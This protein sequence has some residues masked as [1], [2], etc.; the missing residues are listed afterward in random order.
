M[1][2]P[3]DKYRDK[4][5]PKSTTEPFSAERNVRA[6]GETWKGRFVIHQHAASRMHFDVRLEVGGTLQSFAVPRG[7]SLDPED[8][9]LAIHTEDHPLEYLFFEDVIPPG[10]YGAGA[11]IVWDAG[12]VTYLETSGEEGLARG[13]IDFV[14][15]G[16]KAKGRFAFIATGRRKAD[17]GLAGTQGAR[18]EWLLIKKRDAHASKGARLAES[19][20][21]SI[22]SGLTVQ[23]LPQ[24]A[25]LA[26][27]AMAQAAALE[28]KY[29][30]KKNPLPK[31]SFAPVPMVC[32]TEGAPEKSPDWVY[33]LKLDGVRIIAEKAGSDVRLSYRSGRVATRNYRDV[34]RSVSKLIADQTILDGEIVTFD[35]S[36][37]PVFGRLAPRIG[38]RKQVD[39]DKAEATV[40]VVYVV[41]DILELGGHNLRAVPLEE[42][43]ALVKK[44][45]PTLGLVRSLD[46]IV[47][48]G[49]ALWALC[50]A[51]DLEGMIAKRR[52]SPYL[53]GP[54]SS[55]HWV[56][57]KRA[58]DADFVV[59]G[60][61]KGASDETTLGALGLGSYVGGRL[62]YRGRVG[63]GFS[64]EARKQLL[65]ELESRQVDKP[66]TEIPSDVSLTPVA[67]DLVVR[68]RFQG[69]TEDGNV[70]A[71]VYQGLRADVEPRDCTISP[72]DE[73]VVS[74]VEPTT[75]TGQQDV[76]EV[77]RR[78]VIT[79]RDKVYFP[80]DD[81][82][83][84]D[85]LDYYEAIAP[86]MLPHLVERPV[87][88][89]R[90]PDGI[91]G[92]SFYQWRAPEGTPDWVRTFELYD[93]EK[94]A[95]RGSGKAAFLIDGTEALL[96]IA[97][98]G[99]I[100]VHVLACREKSREHCDF[101][102]IDFDIAERPFKDAVLLALSL[103]ELLDDLSLVGFVKTSG[104]R[105]LHVLIPLGPLVPFESA[106]ILCELLG[107]VLV[108]RHPDVATMERRIEKRGDKLYV[109][110]GQ[111][112]RSRT[113]VAPYSVRAIPGARVSTPLYWEELHLALDP[114]VFT[115]LTVVER[116]KARG[117]PMRT[118]LEVR[119]HLPKVLEELSRWTSNLK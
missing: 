110:T 107:R 108:G 42:R 74:T 78:V 22:L 19:M 12:G 8:K 10:N 92:K 11:M 9:H 115:I 37:K 98:L 41:F 76:Q 38:A 29:P 6:E 55:G 64:S 2:G 69:F 3:L 84:G 102:T 106:K 93:E 103:K 44:I 51:Q 60:F 21:Q 87:V 53:E 65:L 97:N 101:I 119:P 27:E 61:T 26:S 57:I 35:E 28:R 99:C 14:L 30:A 39:I 45:I 77:Q 59:V 31:A 4:R 40:P 114:S 33:E 49:D 73:L 34:A 52:G 70:R 96:H 82:K 62:Q 17:S 25:A 18:A 86:F 91:H 36:G 94:Q 66:A 75:N 56:K 80:E 20:P 54:Q 104:Q 111:T 24:R 47:E 58:E 67:P 113:I 85:L 95:E 7:I 118:M 32:A 48:R 83:K 79:N 23:E 105:G 100:P 116:V 63:S 72:N 117:D 50:E 46:H 16:H 5:D 90:Y 68:I 89:V 81:L 112:G 109:D 1:E 15:Q 88:L 43:K 13:K 71:A